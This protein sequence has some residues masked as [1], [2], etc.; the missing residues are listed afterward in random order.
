MGFNTTV[1]VLNDALGSIERDTTFGATL[2]S[3]IK[4]AAIE[5]PVHVHAGGHGNAATVI[6]SHHADTLIPVLI[7]GNKGLELKTYVPW[8]AE[9]PELQLLLQLAHRRGYT[10]RKRRA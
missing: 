8:N 5:R 6:E 2:A 9:D 7:G 3:A 4:Q 1:V 10:L